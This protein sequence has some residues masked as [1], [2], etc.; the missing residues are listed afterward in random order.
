MKSRNYHPQTW[1]FKPAE[2]S[3]CFLRDP[4]E[5]MTQAKNVN[6]SETFCFVEK[7]L[8]P[9]FKVCTS[10]NLLF[11]YGLLIGPQP[12]FLECI[13][14]F[15]CNLIG[16]LCPSGPCYGCRTFT[17]DS[18]RHVWC[19]KS[20]IFKVSQGRKWNFNSER[21]WS[22]VIR[23]K[24]EKVIHYWHPGKNEPWER[25]KVVFLFWTLQ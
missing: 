11:F 24:W 22:H 25:L 6:V 23:E 3:S 10:S 13:V 7:R 5:W 18:S 16:Q 14:N 9:I 20:Y 2:E 21:F 12:S 17:F 19:A 8:L 15:A 4:L 1:P